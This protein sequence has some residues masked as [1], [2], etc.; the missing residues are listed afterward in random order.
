M[1]DFLPEMK[2]KVYYA[3]KIK[4]TV[5]DN[6]ETSNPIGRKLMELYVVSTIHF[7]T[8]LIS[9]MFDSFQKIVDT[10]NQKQFVIPSKNYTEKKTFQLF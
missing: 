5:N 9:S 4:S 1:D 8:K 2:S 3:E 10:M 6:G 7:S